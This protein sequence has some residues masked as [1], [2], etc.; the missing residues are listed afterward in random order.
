M[1]YKS[2]HTFATNRNLLA[3][4]TYNLY[5][6]IPTVCNQPC[7]LGWH[8]ALMVIGSVSLV[9][10]ITLAVIIVIWKCWKGELCQSGLF[11]I[12]NCVL[13]IIVLKQELTVQLCRISRSQMAIIL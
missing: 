11:R 3:S 5:F 13:T 4:A 2:G 6:L 10:G 8:I 1:F 7:L 12:L 9:I